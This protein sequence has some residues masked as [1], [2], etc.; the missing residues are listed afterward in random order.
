[1]RGEQG[2]RAV[3]TGYSDGISQAS[4]GRHCFHAY[5]TSLILSADVGRVTSAFDVF[6]DIISRIIKRILYKQDMHMLRSHGFR[7]I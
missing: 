2:M 6:V 7:I 1:M 4:Y 5:D 3:C